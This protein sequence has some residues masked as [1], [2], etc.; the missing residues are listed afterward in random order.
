MVTPK[1]VI[2]SK[3]F[4]RY[5]KTFKDLIDESYVWEFGIRKSFAFVGSSFLFWFS[6]LP[7]LLFLTPSQKTLL[8]EHQLDSEVV[9]IFIYI[10]I[11][12]FR[13]LLILKKEPYVTHFSFF[14]LDARLSFLVF[15][16]ILFMY[17]TFLLFSFSAFCVFFFLLDFF[18]VFLVAVLFTFSYFV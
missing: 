13:F 16:S 15:L 14:V 3:T 5:R 1:T 4:L 11:T 6:F 8:F 9:K 2:C 12:N 17:W 7:F 10:G 18:R